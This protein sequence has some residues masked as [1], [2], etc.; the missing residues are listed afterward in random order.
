MKNHKLLRAR[1]NLA[2]LEVGIDELL[3]AL[4]SD[5][6]PDPEQLAVAAIELRHKAE[7]LILM[8]LIEVQNGLLDNAAKVLGTELI[9]PPSVCE[10]LE[11]INRHCGGRH[12]PDC[13][14]NAT[15]FGIEPDLGWHEK[16][17]RQGVGFFIGKRRK[18]IKLK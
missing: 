18:K 1:T 12:H 9:H 14:I 16:F 4:F 8:P 11:E 2:S 10:L 13:Y 17:Q 6:K 3:S 15:M 7:A 5:G